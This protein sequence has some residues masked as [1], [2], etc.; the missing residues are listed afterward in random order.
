MVDSSGSMGSPSGN[1]HNTKEWMKN[2]VRAFEIDGR[3]HRIGLIRWSSRVHHESTVRFSDNL[4]RKLFDDKK[5]ER[6]GQ[7]TG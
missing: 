5:L 7:I 2:L 3:H 6:Y 4:S 1:W